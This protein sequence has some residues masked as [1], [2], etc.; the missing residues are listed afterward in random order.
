MA[1]KAILVDTSK[2]IACRGCQVACKQ[3]NELEAEETK[4]FV[5]DSGYQ[6]PPDLSANTY[7]LVTFQLSEKD[8]GDPDW[9]FRKKQC[10][11]CTDAACVSVCPK[12]GEAMQTD[13]STGFVWVNTDNCIGCEQCVS[14]CPFSI[15]RMSEED[16]AKSHKCWACL[17]RI[18]GEINS[19]VVK[20]DPIPACVKT[21]PTGTLEYGDRSDIVSK[22]NARKTKLEEAGKTAYVYGADEGLHHIYVLLREPSSYGLPSAEE[23]NSSSRRAYLRYLREEGKRYAKRFL[24]K[25]A[26]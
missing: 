10:M 26:V 21:C 8:N 14:A 19:D 23:L 5:A 4:F 11:H 12:S 24:G 20:E 7:C 1:E 9:L 16:S 22:A 13:E 18:K 6:N 17:D 15:P 25:I 2:C 3:W